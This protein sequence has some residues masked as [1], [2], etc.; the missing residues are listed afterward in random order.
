[1]LS[2]TTP[3]VGTNADSDNVNRIT[4]SDLQSDMERSGKNGREKGAG[5]YNPLENLQLLQILESTNSYGCG[6]SSPEFKKFYET[7]RHHHH[8]HHHHHPHHHHNFF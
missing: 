5:N 7:L 4:P 3:T 1:M 2:D 6:E 8:H